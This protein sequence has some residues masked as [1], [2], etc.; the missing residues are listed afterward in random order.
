MTYLGKI[1][2]AKTH[3]IGNGG[4]RDKGI[5]VPLLNPVG[6]ISLYHKLNCVQNYSVTFNFSSF[7]F[8]MNEQIP[9]GE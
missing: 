7:L 2:T 4:W 3:T 9:I 5:D 6:I 8:R 1:C